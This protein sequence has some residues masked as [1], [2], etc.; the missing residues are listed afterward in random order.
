M[1]IKFKYFYNGKRHDVISIDFKNKTV[2]FLIPEDNKTELGFIDKIIPYTGKVD[3][4]NIPIFEGD[5]LELRHFC[6][7]N[8]DKHERFLTVEDVDGTGFQLKPLNLNEYGCRHIHR[9]QYDYT[10]IGNKY[11]NPELLEVR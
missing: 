2:R 6:G 4:N 7:V 3:R 10:I 9:T 5:I 11:E 8:C 1:N